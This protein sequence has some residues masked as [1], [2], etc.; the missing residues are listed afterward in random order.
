MQR[1]EL[2]G[3]ISIE[4]DTGP[5]TGRAVQRRRLA[6]LALLAAARSPGVGRDKLVA[7]L[8]PDANA[9]NGRRFLSDSVYRINQA[10]GGDVILAAGDDLRLDAQ[11]LPSDLFE[12]ENALADG[13]HETAVTLYK[14]PF[15]DGFFLSDAAELE[16]WV[17]GERDRL[18]RSQASALEA[19]AEAA[20][21][22][23]DPA[24]SAGWWR[25]LAAH[26]P[27]NSRI[28]LRL[29]QA[30]DAAGERAAAIQ[31]ARVHEALL[32]HDLEIEPDAGVR[33]LAERLRRAGGT[34]QSTRNAQSKADDVLTRAPAN[35]PAASAASTAGA[36]GAVE[37]RGRSAGMLQEPAPAL[38]A[39]REEHAP[40]PR[41]HRPRRGPMP[42]FLWGVLGAVAVA[43]LA[44]WLL[45]RGR[46]GGAAVRISTIAVLPFVNLS[47][48]LDNEYFSDG[49]T[50]ELMMTLGKVD[51]LRVA[52]R[53]SVFAYKDRPVDVREVGE[54]LG[55]EAVV[56][57]SVRKAEGMVRIAAQ[58]VSTVNGYEL[59]SGVYERELE[60]VFAIQEQIS[61][62]IVATLRGSGTLADSDSLRLADRSTQDPEAY[63][64]YLKGRFA[65]H[66]RTQ[67]G[68]KRAVAY[69]GEAVEVAP[70]YARAYVGLGDAYA[71]GA[72]YDY[73]EPRTAYPKA[74][75]A[76]RRALEIDATLA[77]PH[78]TLGYVLT[79][80]HLEW[81]RAEDEFRR[82]LAL[83]PSYSTAHQ[84]Y[85]NLLTVA[86]RFNEAEREMR[87]AQEAD[88]L[89]LIANAALGWSFYY[90]GKYDQ[91]LTQCRTT[92][93]LNPDY[94][95]AHL[96]GGWA[97]QATGQREQ[98]R[99]WIG[100]AVRLS[101]GSVLT[102]LSL[103]QL[104]A[105]SASVAQRDSARGI[106]REVESYAER[107]DYVPAYEIAKVHLALGDRAEAL[108]WLERAYEDRSHSMA[109][110]R[111]DPQLAP[112]RGDSRFEA[113][114]TR[115]LG[116]SVAGAGD[117]W[118]FRWRPELSR[119]LMTYIV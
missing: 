46:A 2:F 51:G 90:A 75:A 103:A 87:L 59:W 86:A 35:V 68:L 9:E 96:W 80:F 14:G 1:L 74:E 101:E 102:R 110:L 52:S 67:E 108:D 78:A 45:G 60:D 11:R 38:S 64:L 25:R 105:G 113:L 33:E 26:D 73:L 6:L 88:P 92:L 21:R 23:Q 71:V 104:L 16:R 82:A 4:T 55:V 72:F 62:A 5:V 117:G 8:W 34:G 98:A 47:A 83:D 114:V 58:L 32:T 119:P 41:R 20:E 56:E 94:Q 31:H 107:G 30:L 42:T 18:A 79:Y 77:A 12:F 70:N 118:H 37:A 22:M 28:A 116:R 95:L 53:T 15:L 10:L 17:E 36:A 111:V 61:H 29:M 40:L 66:Q 54:R 65:W 85:A 69:F 106:V 112:L 89:S 7:Y 13:A 43:G 109:F 19:L 57:G 44:V 27:Y 3:G 39:A 76:A 91:A 84:W 115:A 93:T 24:A 100:R 50:E 48:D 99:E 49:M 81:P 97:L 63:D